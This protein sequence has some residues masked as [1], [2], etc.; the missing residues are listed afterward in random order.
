MFKNEA[1]TSASIVASMLL[2]IQSVN[3]IKIYSIN[4]DS[5]GI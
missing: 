4:V 5:N 2:M 3:I 1:S